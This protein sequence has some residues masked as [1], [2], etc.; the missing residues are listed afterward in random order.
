MAATFPGGVKTFTTKQGG[1]QIGS[2]HINDLQLEV[3]AVETELRK[4]TGSVVDHGGLTGLADN[5]HPQYL[6]ADGTINVAS[7]VTTS[8]G[9]FPAYKALVYSSS[10][11][12]QTW[13]RVALIT[14]G[15]GTYAG[16]SF[17]VEW[18]VG[19]GNWGQAQPIRYVYDVRCVRSNSVED[20]TN[21]AYIVGNGINLQ[22]VKTSTGVFEIQVMSGYN[23]C[24]S[25]IT[26]KPITASYCTFDFGVA[27][28]GTGT[29][30]SA[31]WNQA[32][33]IVTLDTPISVYMSN[34]F[35]VNTTTTYDVYTLGIPVTA[36]MVY[37]R[38]FSVWSAA[39]ANNYLV[40]E[41]YGTSNVWMVARA[42]VANMGFDTQGW[43]EVDESGRFNVTC[44][45]ASTSA[46]CSATIYAYME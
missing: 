43:V 29:I 3:V 13:K 39:S 37:I 30:Y 34:A 6:L 1:D 38:A 19:A 45:G 44:S 17:K 40:F 42:M 15:T 16:A 14:I 12:A 26:I 11:E 28:A 4:T 32:N 20:D 22:V 31:T 27:T 36:K 9:S 46:Y 2:A 41:K 21:A 35:T 24:D 5:D 10:A 23:D 7:G 33:R 25:Q 18:I 8:G